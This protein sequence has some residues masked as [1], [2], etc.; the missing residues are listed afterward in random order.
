MSTGRSVEIVDTGPQ[1]TVQ[2]LGRPGHAAL[3]V[4]RSGAADRD[5]LTLANRLLGNPESHAALETTLGGLRLRAYGDV[6]VV[7]TGA[8]CAV[9]VDGREVGR[10]AP[11][12]VPAG[13]V[14]ALG[15]PSSGLRSYV[16]VRGG[17]DVAPV[18]GSRSQDT[19]SGVGPP[20]VSEGDELPVGSA[21]QTPPPVDLAPVP[22]PEDGPIR[23]EVVPGPRADWFTD[24]A[25]ETLTSTSYEVTS[26]S[27]RVGM[28]LSGEVLTRRIED[29]LPSEG[30]VP[31]ALQVPPSG[32]PTLFL[33]DHPV[34][35]GYPV[36]A[37][38]RDAY[39]SRAAQARPGQQL[40][41]ARAPGSAGPD[42]TDDG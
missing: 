11:V 38:V 21:P 35:G 40:R 2:D 28:R 4:G 16:G 7:V 19:L 10:N 17:V 23:L 12:R 37:V 9:T 36:I 5:A 8:P 32:Q 14:L 3:G 42:R 39:L 6:V 15:P 34:T 18:L 24:E 31:G 1:T 13:G 41:F 20:A 30:M 29:E 25:L 27:N 22:A 26:D 33:A